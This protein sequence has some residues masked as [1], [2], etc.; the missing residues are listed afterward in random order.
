MANAEDLIREA[1]Y[2]FRNIGPGAT[3]NRKYT[4]R[5]KRIA[6]R[7]VRNYPASIEAAQ[8]RQILDRLGEPTALIGAPSSPL[9]PS[10]LS[11][12]PHAPHS[13][14]HEQ[15][16]HL[17]RKRVATAAEPDSWARIWQRITALTTMQKKVLGT[18]LVFGFILVS[19]M[20]FLLL[21]FA[22]YA[23][24]PRRIRKD[25]DGLLDAL[26]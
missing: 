25:I 22:Y 1:E 10:P 5:A 4:A 23:V 3:D 6:T 24:K 12:S 18:I 19:A 7:I 21:I 26:V 11:P 14:E 16:A 20:P 2:A 8:A 13:A 17:P 15:Q 9:S